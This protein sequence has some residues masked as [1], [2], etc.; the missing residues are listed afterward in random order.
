MKL[1]DNNTG[2]LW[3]FMFLLL[4]EDVQF[5]VSGLLVSGSLWEV[6]I[7]QVKGFYEN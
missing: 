2:H 5:E 1:L 7:L 6:V 3:S 4:Q